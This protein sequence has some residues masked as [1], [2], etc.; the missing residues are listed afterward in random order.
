MRH[1]PTSVTQ[2]ELG[3]PSNGAIAPRASPSFGM[4]SLANLL[5]LINEVEANPFASPDAGRHG[6]ELS[7]KSQADTT[8]GWTFQGRTRHTPK[9]TSPPQEQH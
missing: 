9:L 8:E 7:C 4:P 3:P 6:T 5:M 1:C 2:P